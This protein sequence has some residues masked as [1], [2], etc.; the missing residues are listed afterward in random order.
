MPR[1]AVTARSPRSS[2]GG[3]AGDSQS[4][5]SLRTR[6]SSSRD[7][8]GPTSGSSDIT[9]TGRSTPRSARTVGVRSVS[10]VGSTT[11]TT[12]PSSRATEASS[13]WGQRTTSGPIRHG[14]WCA[15]RAMGGSTTRSAATGG[16]RR[17]SAAGSTRHTASPF[18]LPTDGSSQLEPP[19]VIMIRSRWLAISSDRPVNR[20]Q[21]GAPV[22][23]RAGRPASIRRSVTFF[24]RSAGGRPSLGS[25]IQLQAPHTTTWM[26][27]CRDD[28]RTSGAI[29]SEPHSGHT[30]GRSMM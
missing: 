28:M 24:E 12:S 8:T 14:Q 21:R 3:R 11:P 15:S 20:P 18:S 29:S 22:E 4:G 6:R 17:S 26:R 2:S 16:L 5:S 19:M 23:R 1:S 10:R 9:P 30:S 27:P 7:R 25:E 13:P